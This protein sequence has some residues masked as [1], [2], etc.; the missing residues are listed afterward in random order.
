MPEIRFEA[1]AETV[2]DGNPTHQ[3]TRQTVASFTKTVDSFTKTVT[4]LYKY[5]EDH[6]AHR[7]HR[8]DRRASSRGFD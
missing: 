7:I 6:D 5:Q 2:A 1:R 8:A 4:H 3:D